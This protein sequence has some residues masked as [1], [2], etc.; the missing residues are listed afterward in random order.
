MLIILYFQF[1]LNS[2]K[3]NNSKVTNWLSD[4]Q[5]KINRCN[6]TIYEYDGFKIGIDTK[7]RQIKIKENSYNL[8]QN[9][10]LEINNITGKINDA[11]YIIKSKTPFQIKKFMLDSFIKV[12][13]IFFIWNDESN[14]KHD[15]ESYH[16]KID[17]IYDKTENCWAGLKE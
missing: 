15:N 1:D 13:Q 6:I 9:E 2:C 8:S 4:A 10:E 17:A 3:A 16:N 14:L 11:N 12:I 7:P 5:I